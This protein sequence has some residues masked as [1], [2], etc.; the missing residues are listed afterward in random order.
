MERKVEY[1][2]ALLSSVQCGS[3][4]VRA[5]RRVASRET[6]HSIRQGIRSEILRE[7]FQVAIDALSKRY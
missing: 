1:E 4:R 6:L 5:D 2:M 7:D 3:I